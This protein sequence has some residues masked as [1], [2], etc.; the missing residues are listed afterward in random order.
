MYHGEKLNFW[1]V[2]KTWQWPKTGFRI[3][4]RK[5]SILC[6]QFFP[7]VLFCCVIS[8]CNFVTIVDSIPASSDT[9]GSEVRQMK[10]C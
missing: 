10:Q 9:V 3:K 5:V 6:R 4:V 8:Q 7:K 1:P 2:E